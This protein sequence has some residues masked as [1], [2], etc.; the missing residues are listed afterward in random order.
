MNNA[1]ITDGWLYGL[2]SGNTSPVTG[3]IPFASDDT[4]SFAFSI[5]IAC[6]FI[7]KTI[8]MQI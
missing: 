1:R 8:K 4:I 7:M 6:D 5:S 2:S 3:S